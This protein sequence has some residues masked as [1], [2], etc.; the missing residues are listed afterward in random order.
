MTQADIVKTAFHVWGRQFYQSTSLTDIARELGV[1]K[2]ALYRHFKDKKALSETMYK[3]FF[4]DYADFLRPFYNK[5]CAL[6]DQEG[7]FLMTRAVAEYYARH[8]YGFIF[9]LVNVYGGRE[10]GHIRTQLLE[11]GIDIRRFNQ[12][13]YETIFAF[14]SV[15][16]ILAHF[17]K[18]HT[19]IDDGCGAF[20]PDILTD[21]ETERIV[22]LA[23]DRIRN[24]LRLSAERVHS[25]DYAGIEEKAAQVKVQDGGDRLLRAVAAAIAESGAAEAGAGTIPVSVIARKSGLSKSSLYSHFENKRDMLFSLFT[26]EFDR[27]TAL[28]EEAKNLCVDAE[29]RLYAMIIAIAGYLRSSPD[30]LSALDWLRTR[31]G[32]YPQAKRKGYSGVHEK[33]PRMERFCTLFADVIPSAMYPALAPQLILFLIVN[34]LMC[35]LEQD[36]ISEEDNRRFRRLFEFVALGIDG[37]AHA[38]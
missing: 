15:T 21:A 1:S 9:S 33:S 37:R 31:T 30:I 27:V 22:N 11:R 18:R 35:G 17:H 7:F 32:D 23:E 19:Q 3:Y 29:E 8:P 28:A 25:I 13:S 26:A 20:I 4:D 2:P 38:G 10:M 34:T 36:S 16:F 14:A 12:D 24:G 6:P 5:A